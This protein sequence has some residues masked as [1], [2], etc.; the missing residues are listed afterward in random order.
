MRKRSAAHQHVFYYGKGLGSIGSENQYTIGNVSETRKV[1]GLIELASSGFVPESPAKYAATA[2][3]AD[4][5]KDFDN[6][7]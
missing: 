3:T 1:G 5:I 6:I 2:Y 4:A 7:L